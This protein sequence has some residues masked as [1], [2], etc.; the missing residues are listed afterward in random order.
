MMARLR[1][2]DLL[3][4]AVL[5]A[6]CLAAWYATGS[7]PPAR[8]TAKPN[9]VQPVP[10]D[11][12]VYDTARRLAPRA[13]T[14]DEQN[15]AAQALHL[16]DQELDQAF[17]TAL[18]E[19]AVPRRLPPGPL[20]ELASRIA[21][22]QARVTAGQQA[23]AKLGGRPGGAD[24]DQSQLAKA[25]LA[26]DQEELEEARQDLAREGGDVHAILEHALAEHEAA[27]GQKLQPAKDSAASPETLAAQLKTWLELRADGRE[28]ASAQQQAAAKATALGREHNALESMLGKQ[29]KP[30]AAQP[31]A[32]GAATAATGGDEEEEEEDPA[33]MLDRLRRLS[34][35]RKA[36]AELDRRIQYSQQLG[37]VYRR[38]A[39]LV[40]ARQSAVLH[41]LL[42][43]LSAILA[44]VLGVMAA[45]KGIR[46]AFSHHQ[47]RRRLYQQR[48]LA[49]IA[50]QVAGAGLILLVVFGPPGQTPTMIGLATAGL[51]VALKDF[52]V[53]FFGWF[54]LLG[55]N[56]IRLGDWVEI[57]GVGGEVIEIGILKT[58]LLEMG[59]W[60]ST[61]HPT[62]RR[63]AFV[64]S[65]AIEGHYFNFSTAGQW[66][67][68]EL[69]LTL[70]AGGDAYQMAQQIR[71]AVERATDADARQAGQ[72]WERVTR[73]YGVRT[74]SARPVVDLRPGPL[75]LDVIVRY[76]TR[77]PQRYEVKS[78]LFQVIV[79]LVHKPAA[80]A[81][82]G[83]GSGI[84]GTP[85]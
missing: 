68:D 27:H 22:L 84:A 14:T 36:L 76:I 42:L 77:A 70:P 9:A 26:L 57:N 24:S 20:Q 16:A 55:R 66:L 19:A 67:W 74:F 47:D 3:A 59:N 72:D 31:E 50:V 12:K 30:A 51:T 28:L 75:G 61:G 7:A 13:G 10:I 80:A 78:R 34:D 2:W 64:N 79:E 6:A 85:A 58:V 46:G 83:R 44:V 33:A 56:G 49:T 37:D 23:V 43:S 71:D 29:A 32:A 63:V 5:L 25:Q 45:R 41:L 38:W 8:V 15:L 53:A 60:A 62:G 35:Q 4:V 40:E 21:Q 81:H 11:Q 39:G 69:Q 82:S 1:N 17:A 52:I 65:F 18:R 73:Q 54:V 48:L